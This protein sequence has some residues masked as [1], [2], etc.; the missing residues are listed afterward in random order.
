MEKRFVTPLAKALAEKLGINIDLV[1]GSGPA[2]RVLREDV[3]AFS[4]NP[5]PTQPAPA[6]V[7][8]PAPAPAT[9]APAATVATSQ[10]LTGKVEK[11]APIRKAI[12]KAMKTSWASVAYVNLVNEIDVT[13]LW[14]LR[15]KVVDDIQKTTGLKITFLSFISKAILIALQEF[16]ILAA[17]YDE[18]TESLVYPSTINLGIAV[19]T[20]AG[21]MVPVIKD[22]QN[23]SMVQIGQEINRLAKAARD[24]KI[25]AAEMSGGS[26]T[27]TNYG[28]VGALYGV[29]VINYPEIAIAGVGA[30]QS[31]VRWVNGQATE[32]KVMH[33]TVAADH[34]WVDGGTIGRFISRVKEL[35][36][37]P[38]ILG[39][40]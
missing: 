4:K 17:K 24:R 11:V 14:N 28:S 5:Q 34:R 7:A 38:E 21:L 22:A 36:E 10:G 13:N 1:K 30:I 29:P 18:A 2:G 23:L 31:N 20:E 6:Q 8:T 33:L 32:G 19:D 37:K 27:I 12:A 35:L 3:L 40:I 25:K 15:K 39:I 9:P 16:P 26:F